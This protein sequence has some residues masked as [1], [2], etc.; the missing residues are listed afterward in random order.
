[1]EFNNTPKN[2]T[3]EGPIGVGK[4]SLSKKLASSLGAMLLLEKPSENPFLER[5]YTSPECYALPTQL[6]FLFQRVQ[7]LAEVKAHAATGVGLVAD[8]M[9]AKDPMFAELN[10]DWHEVTLYQQVYDSLCIDAPAPDLMIYL[11]APVPVL[12]KRIKKRSIKYEQNIEA[13]YL[14]N[15]SDAYTQYFHHY[16]E[17]SLLI[18]NAAEIN[19]IDNE[20]HYQALVHHI[21]RIDAGKHFFNPLG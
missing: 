1:M 17:S 13:R 6:F 16:N 5:F 15:L 19:P 21:Q 8:F 11:Q 18:V 7:Q 4:S 2:I 9:L 14:Q 20:E 3:I 12:Q 10:L